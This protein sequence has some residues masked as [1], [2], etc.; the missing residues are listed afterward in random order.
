MQN[1]SRAEAERLLG[2]SEKLLYARDLNGSRDFALLSQETDPLLDGPDQIIAI[3]DV[4]L[5]TEKRVSPQ[6]SHHDWYSI[7]QIPRPSDDLDLIKSQYR[8]L[9]LLLHPDKNKYPFADQAFRFAAAAWTI[10]SEPSRKS[11]YDKEFANSPSPFAGVDLT[12]PPPSSSSSKLPVRRNA[13]EFPLPPSQQQMGSG[14]DPGTTNVN[15]HGNDDADDGEPQGPVTFWTACPYCYVLYE[16]P[17]EYVDYCLRCEG[18]QRA[19][20]AILIESPPPAVPG[21]EAYN[22]CWGMFP[23][24]FEIGPVKTKKVAQAPAPAPPPTGG[25]ALPDWMGQPGGAG[26]SGGTATPAKRKRGRPRKN[27]VPA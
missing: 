21:K 23:L 14:A 24:G 20:Q 5:A 8:R 25:E 9:A 4:L 6:S 10:L 26:A 18:C 27:P 17:G 19:F 22:C 7:L 3:V 2:V 12:S 15:S 1:P 13:A 11:L 16:Y